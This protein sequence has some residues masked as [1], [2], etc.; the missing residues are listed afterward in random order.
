MFY[1]ALFGLSS[2]FR[3]QY[4]ASML[5]C[6]IYPHGYSTAVCLAPFDGWEKFIRIRQGQH[7]KARLRLVWLNPDLCSKFQAHNVECCDLY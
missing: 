7:C 1:D 5:P 4:V 6:K 2:L 3:M